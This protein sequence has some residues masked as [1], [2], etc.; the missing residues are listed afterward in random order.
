VLAILVP[1]M[2]G[3]VALAAKDG[4]RPFKANGTGTT[5]VSSTGNPLVFDSESWGTLNASHLGKTASYIDAQ[6]DWTRSYPD[7]FADPCADVVN[8]WMELTA[9]N[10]DKLWGDLSGEV[11]ED[12]PYDN[13]SYTSDLEWDVTGGTGRFATADGVVDVTGHSTRDGLS[14]PTLDDTA[15]MSGWISY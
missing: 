12:A 14:D 8:G 7:Y 13:T 5:E 1:A 2:I 9:A 6:Q 4:K 11:C 10:G 15:S 3:S